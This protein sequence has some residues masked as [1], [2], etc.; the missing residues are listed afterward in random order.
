MKQQEHY[1]RFKIQPWDLI[2]SYKLTY[3]EGAAVKYIARNRFKNGNEDLLKA[4]HEL[5]RELSLRGVNVGIVV[6]NELPGV[7]S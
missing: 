5:Q 6:Q 2:D 4:M 3:H 1:G 7:N